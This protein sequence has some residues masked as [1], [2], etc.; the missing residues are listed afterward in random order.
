MNLRQL[1]YFLVLAEELHFRRAAERLNITQSP[2][3]VAIQELERELGGKLFQ[4]TQ[5]RVEL[6]EAG[7][8]FRIGA[9]EVLDRMQASLRMTRDILSGRPQRLRL[10]LT[11]ATGLLPF[12]GTTI[13]R[14]H[15]AHPEV[16]VTL[17]ELPFE[18][19]SRALQS[20][21]L[22][23]CVVRMPL[24]C[25]PK[26]GGSIKL[27]QERLIVVMHRDHPLRSRRAALTI[28]DLQ[29]DPFIVY[30]RSA[31]TGL[32]EIVFELCAN[33]SFA[34]RI[35]HETRDTAAILGLCAARQGI[36]V[37]PAE[38]SR[39]SMPDVHFMPLVDEDAATNIHLTFRETPI[40]PRVAS[41]CG[42][43]EGVVAHGQPEA[44]RIGSAPQV[45]QRTRIAHSGGAPS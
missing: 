27:L 20:Q 32:H 22:D 13:Q 31:A 40:D 35:V 7:A 8:A 5:R 1:R 6:T 21:E 25:A 43:A 4:R 10:G 28:T 16:R 17:H 36:A 30:P 12:L 3:T 41:L 9:R 33:R 45:W 26:P 2:L 29:D 24:T 38:L 39:I 19:D 44:A 11:T 37:V 42:I 15:I 18:E 23:A 14:F 34:P